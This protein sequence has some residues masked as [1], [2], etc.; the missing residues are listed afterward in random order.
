[1][2]TFETLSAKTRPGGLTPRLGRKQIVSDNDFGSLTEFFNSLVGEL[3]NPQ[4]EPELAEIIEQALQEDA[5]RTS[6]GEVPSPGR[7]NEL[8][9]TKAK[10]PA[11]LGEHLLAAV[12]K[13]EEI[14]G[15]KTDDGGDHGNERHGSKAG[16][17][18]A[19]PSNN[20]ATSRQA[21]R[22][23]LFAGDRRQANQA[24]QRVAAQLIQTIAKVA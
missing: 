10:E 20:G 2:P 9:K 22:S 3:E 11:N 17:G 6:S 15:G 18:I 4:D 12:G 7:G 16:G 5:E 24:G 14:S 21:S 19:G 1:V 23:R 13:A 8:H